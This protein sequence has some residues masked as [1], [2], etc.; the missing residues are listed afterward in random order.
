[1]TFSFESFRNFRCLTCSWPSSWASRIATVK[2]KN[3]KKHRW[4]QVD[5]LKSLSFP[6]HPRGGSSVWVANTCSTSEVP[7]PAGPVGCRGFQARFWWIP[8]SPHQRPKLQMHHGLMYG[9]HHLSNDTLHSTVQ[10]TARKWGGGKSHVRFNGL[11]R[12]TAVVKMQD[13]SQI[14]WA[15]MFS[16]TMLL[17]VSSK[18]LWFQEGWSPVS[19]QNS[20]CENTEECKVWGR[21]LY[22][23]LCLANN[24]KCHPIYC[25][26]SIIIVFPVN[27]WAI[28]T[29]DK[30]HQVG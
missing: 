26:P 5:P 22:L 29:N 30:S 2:K 20:V 8:K 13:L 7:I 19:S 16:V 12:A 4:S 11:I 27:M 14:L 17:Q 15:R 28:W 25:N 18:P 21:S 9:Y 6:W 24:S 23:L 10:H 3:K 1:M